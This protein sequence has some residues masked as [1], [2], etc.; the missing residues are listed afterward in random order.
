MDEWYYQRGGATFGPIGARQLLA[1]RERGSLSDETLLRRGLTGDWTA[2]KEAALSEAA[3]TLP[4]PLPPPMAAHPSP[5]TTRPGTGRLAAEGPSGWLWFLAVCAVMLT[6]CHGLVLV[7]NGLSFVLATLPP[8][9]LP[10]MAVT[11]FNFCSEALVVSSLLYFVSIIIWTGAAFA[12]LARVYGENNVPH[13]SGAGFWW[14][15]P[16][17]NLVMPFRCLRVIQH[18]S[19]RLRHAVGVETSPSLSVLGIQVAYIATT[20]FRVLDKVS[21]PSAPMFSTSAE[22]S[23]P[24]FAMMLDFTLAAF[25]LQLAIFIL[26][27]L[28]QQVRLFDEAR[29]AA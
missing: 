17:A 18:L 19:R 21:S 2:L 1:L 25:A 14:I 5:V 13:G 16:F 3:A 20:I 29:D 10:D 7:V 28:I 6:A 22:N 8:L 15:V 12:S 23:N 26:I 9:E 24:F 11:L 27:N 4:P